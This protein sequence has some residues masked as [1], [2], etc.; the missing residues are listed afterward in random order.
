MGD[1][2]VVPKERAA[3]GVFVA[4]VLTDSAKIVLGTALHLKQPL[5]A[6]ATHNGVAVDGGSLPASCRSG[7]AACVLQAS[8]PFLGFFAGFRVASLS[9]ALEEGFA[10]ANCVVGAGVAGATRAGRVH[11]SCMGLL[12]EAAPLATW[13]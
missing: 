6:L 9:L 7:Q 1:M 3:A 12:V 13:R 10:T 11:R 2:V 4:V 5:R 8:A